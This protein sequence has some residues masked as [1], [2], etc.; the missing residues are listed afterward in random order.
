[1][2]NSHDCWGWI[3]MTEPFEIAW[4]FLK[5]DAEEIYAMYGTFTPQ[6]LPGWGEEEEEEVSPGRHTRRGAGG[7]FIPA[8]K[9]CEMEH[10][11]QHGQWYNCGQELDDHH[12]D[13]FDV[14]HDDRNEGYC[15]D[16]MGYDEKW[17]ELN[18]Y[19][20][21]DMSEGKYAEYYK[22]NDGKCA[23]TGRELGWP[24]IL[25]EE[26]GEQLPWVKLDDEGYE[27]A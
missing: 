4:N 6:D 25:D 11:N 9:Y 18:P 15:G 10:M 19:F 17:D 2:R 26:T 7:K 23:M 21:D 20:F 24:D 27:L 1:M 8:R 3:E 22:K 14:P 13:R 5:G 12:F 16:C